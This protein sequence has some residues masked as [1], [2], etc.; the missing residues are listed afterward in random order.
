MDC[1]EG[2]V[3]AAFSVLASYELFYAKQYAGMSESGKKQADEKRMEE[4]AAVLTAGGLDGQLAQDKK[5]KRA[6][7]RLATC[8]VELHDAESNPGYDSESDTGDYHDNVSSARWNVARVASK[9]AERPETEG[10]APAKR[11]RV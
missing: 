7:D 2:K 5:V 11:A 9:A 10:E 4:R 8:E 3:I 6:F 1:D